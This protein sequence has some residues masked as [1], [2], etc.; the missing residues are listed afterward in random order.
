MNYADRP[1]QI[2]DL[3]SR[4]PITLILNSRAS[5][6]TKLLLNYFTNISSAFYRISNTDHPVEIC[7]F[8]LLIVFILNRCPSFIFELLLNFVEQ[9]SASRV[10][11]LDQITQIVRSKFLISSRPPIIPIVQAFPSSPS[12]DASF[13]SATDV[14]PRYLPC[15]RI[16]VYNVWMSFKFV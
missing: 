12:S 7:L 5:F 1:F 14:P 6:V 11:F 8:R 13:A 10:P 4:L 16:G 3:V 9:K 15:V 2:F